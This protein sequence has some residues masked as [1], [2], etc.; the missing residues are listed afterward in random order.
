MKVMVDVQ[1]AS[2]TLDERDHAGLSVLVSVGGYKFA[3]PSRN[4]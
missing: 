1:A 3:S 4:T 2:K